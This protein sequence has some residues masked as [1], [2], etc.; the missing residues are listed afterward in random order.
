MKQYKL[1]SPTTMICT[2]CAQAGHQSK[3]CPHPITSYGVILFRVKD[4]W[5]QAE[6]LVKGSVTGLEMSSKLEYLLIQRRDTIAFIEV[7]RGKYRTN[8]H[9]Y[10]KQHLSCMTGEERNKLCTS[11]FDALWESVWGPPQEGTHAYRNE[12]EQAKGKLEIIRPLLPEL[13]ADCKEPWSAPE[14]GFP[15]GR[16]ENGESEYAC[17]MRELWEETN[18]FEKEIYP[19]R[20]MEPIKEIFVGSNGVRYCHK[21]YMAY[22]VAGVGEESIEVA[23]QKNEHIRREVSCMKWLSCDEAIN[24]I[25]PENEE[26]RRVLLRVHKALQTYCPLALTKPERKRLL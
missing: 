24:N 26:K 22:A 19:V 3:Q 1:F 8:D 16:R 6:N 10:I 18:I 12:K 7:M 17:A 20:N 2:N 14:W 21:Y 11:D 23:A 13:I 4:G 25:R 15:K 9:E 5:E